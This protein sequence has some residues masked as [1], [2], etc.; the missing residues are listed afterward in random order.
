MEKRSRGRP[1]VPTD[2]HYKRVN[3]R[4]TPDV[5]KKLEDI[6]EKMGAAWS[7]VLAM[8]VALWEEREM[9]L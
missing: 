4:V 3:A 9:P 2:Q 1:K 8:L 5:M 6:K 7:E